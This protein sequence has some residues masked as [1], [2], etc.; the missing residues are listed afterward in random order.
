MKVD[1]IIKFSLDNISNKCH[2]IRSAAKTIIS[3]L[4]VYIVRFDTEQMLKI[5]NESVTM[6]STSSDNKDWHLLNKFKT[7]LQQQQEVSTQKIDN[8]M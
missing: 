8:L 5:Q 7:I 1:D 3:Q 2:S 4:G 6:S